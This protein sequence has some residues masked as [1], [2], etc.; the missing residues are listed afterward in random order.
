MTQ[1]QIKITS[2][3]IKL[4]SRDT[5]FRK[6]LEKVFLIRY[7]L[8]LYNR[9]NKTMYFSWSSTVFEIHGHEGGSIALERAGLKSSKLARFL[10]SILFLYKKN[11]R[12]CA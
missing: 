10:D 11:P 5:T 7:S 6:A 12:A 1:F 4:E 2:E 3:R 9:P 8:R